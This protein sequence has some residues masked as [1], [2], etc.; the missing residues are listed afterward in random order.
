M[1]GMV[2]RIEFPVVRGDAR[3]LAVVTVNGLQVPITFPEPASRHTVNLYLR[4]HPERLTEEPYTRGWL[5]EAQIESEPARD[6]FAR[7]EEMRSRIGEQARSL[8]EYLHEA[9]PGH[10]GDGG[11]FERGLLGSLPRTEALRIYHEYNPQSA[12]WNRRVR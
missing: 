11:L 7:A 8:Q 5:F 10:A 4:A 3:P 9:V 1:L 2:T 12:G 6:R